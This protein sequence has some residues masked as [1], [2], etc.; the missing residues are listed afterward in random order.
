MALATVHRADAADPL[1]AYLTAKFNKFDQV[2]AEGWKKISPILTQS[3]VNLGP[4]REN[5]T[6]ARFN[7]AYEKGVLDPAK[8]LE[9]YGNNFDYSKLLECYISVIKDL[10]TLNELKANLAQVSDGHAIAQVVKKFSPTVKQEIKLQAK[11]TDDRIDWN[12]IVKSFQWADENYVP[13]EVK[14]E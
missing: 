5:E 9:L 3:I 4:V 14:S 12:N 6:Y 10:E 1:S 2:S 13:P 11:Y 8:G 7:A